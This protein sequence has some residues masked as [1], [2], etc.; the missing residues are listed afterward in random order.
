MLERVLTRGLV[1]KPGAGNR[2]G[3]DHGIE[4]LVVRA[5]AYRVERVAARLDADRGFEPLRA[6]RLQCEREYERLGDR[7]DREGYGAFANLIDVAIERR[8][9][10]A[11][12]RRIGFGQ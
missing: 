11:E 5:K 12:M 6:H 2:A 9:R 7:L 3:I 8:E 10:D 1:H 4:R